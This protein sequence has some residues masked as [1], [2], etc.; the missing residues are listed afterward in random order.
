[1]NNDSDSH[2]PTLT[3]VIQEGDE[4]MRNHFDA[5][6]FNQQQSTSESAAHENASDYENSDYKKT[7]TEDVPSIQVTL[8]DETELPEEDF[9]EAMQSRINE[10]GDVGGD[11]DEKIES[12]DTDLKQ[13]IDQAINEALPQVEEQLKQAIYRKFGL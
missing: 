2:I 8:D 6:Q 1:M 13:K 3:H 9:S 10:L 12:A 5:H 4:S 7:E 11:T